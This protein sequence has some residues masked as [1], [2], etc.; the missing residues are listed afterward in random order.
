MI[1]PGD[2]KKSPGS[3]MGSNTYGEHHAGLSGRVEEVQA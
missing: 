2:S 3:L 1:K